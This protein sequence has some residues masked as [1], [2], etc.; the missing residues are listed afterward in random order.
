[1]PV[2]CSTHS[3]QGMD[4]WAWR[5]MRMGMS[6]LECTCWVMYMRAVQPLL[7]MI[8]AELG[9][10]EKRL[11]RHPSAREVAATPMS[12]HMNATDMHASRAT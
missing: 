4:F 9:T 8:L 10:I 7:A 2:P 1:M 3:L 5:E 6:L 11:A 12:R